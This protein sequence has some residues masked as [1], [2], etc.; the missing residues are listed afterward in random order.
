MKW[1]PKT[2]GNTIFQSLM[3]VGGH[4][5]TNWPTEVATITALCEFDKKEWI[6]HNLM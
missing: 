6:L 3:G 2:S 1:Q 5:G 4:C